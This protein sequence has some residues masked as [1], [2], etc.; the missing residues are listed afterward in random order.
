MNL[1]ILFLKIRL[2]KMIA[3]LE[4]PFLSD[5][6]FQFYNLDDGFPIKLSKLINSEITK[7]NTVC[8]FRYNLL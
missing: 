7:S 4:L 1:E 8:L 2:T 3:L 6:Q 5:H